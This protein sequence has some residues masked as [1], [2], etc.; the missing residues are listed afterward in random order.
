MRSEHDATGDGINLGS[1]T[2]RPKANVRRDGVGRTRE[3]LRPYR[4]DRFAAPF[5]RVRHR[6][7]ADTNRGL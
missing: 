2:E 5:K 1:G 7:E 4:C 3:S 6:L